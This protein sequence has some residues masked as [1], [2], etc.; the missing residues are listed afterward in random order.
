M[1]QPKRRR[2]T[3]KPKVWPLLPGVLVMPWSDNEERSLVARFSALTDD[4]PLRAVRQWQPGTPYGLSYR[5]V[6]D[7]TGRHV[8]FEGDGFSFIIGLHNKR[9]RLT[10]V[11]GDMTAFQRWLLL[12]K[13]GT[14]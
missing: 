4:I 14:P 3:R 7:M 9:H 8:L 11:Q 1:A 6:T 12:S 10:R 5:R 13:L 2:P